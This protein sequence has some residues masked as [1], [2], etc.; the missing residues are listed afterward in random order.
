MH[1]YCFV[2][3]IIGFDVEEYSVD[4]GSHHAIFNVTVFS[5][6]LSSAVVVEFFTEDGSGQGKQEN[7]YN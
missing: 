6:M 3:T 7:F 5:G 1:N 4:E 2:E